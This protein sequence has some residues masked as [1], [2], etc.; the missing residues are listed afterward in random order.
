[1]APS[2]PTRREILILIT[3]LFSLVF[4]SNSNK[5][6]A[7]FFSRPLD[8]I[9]NTSHIA[10]TWQSTTIPETTVVTHTPGQYILLL[11]IRLHLCHPGWTIFD[12]LYIFK[13]VIFIVTDS[14]STIPDLSFICSKGIFVLP[15]RENELLRLPTEENIRIVSSAQAKQLFGS[16]IQTMDGVTVCFT[17]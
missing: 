8:A 4:L 10:T 15:G 5:P 17:R 12:Q 9:L 6:S 16:G 1:M 3:L 7:P 13:G 2:P 14:P 11:Y